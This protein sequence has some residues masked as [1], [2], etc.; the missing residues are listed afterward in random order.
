[1]PNADKRDIEQGDK[2][3]KSDTCQNPNDQSY[4]E[5]ATYGKKIDSNQN[6]SVANSQSTAEKKD[7][8]SKN[9]EDK[10]QEAKVPEQK[11]GNAQFKIHQ[12]KNQQGAKNFQNAKNNLKEQV[13]AKQQQYED[14][15]KQGSNKSK[16][17]WNVKDD[18]L[19]AMKWSANKY[20]VLNMFEG[21]V[22]KEDIGVWKQNEIHKY[23]LLKRGPTDEERVK[24]DDDMI[25][26]F[27]YHWNSWKKDSKKVAEEKVELEEVAPVQSESAA[28]ISS[29][30]IGGQRNGGSGRNKMK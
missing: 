1:M 14:S 6:A 24:W 9:K 28:F 21:D 25:E 2:S 18:L 4:T 3:R 20:S 29:N 16:K 26:E 12:A 11:K 15:A 10:K 19:P 17:T 7:N 5:K 13:N 23:M 30:E 27:E 8:S 22:Y